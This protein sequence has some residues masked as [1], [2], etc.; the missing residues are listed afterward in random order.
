MKR[1][2]FLK[3]FIFFVLA[4]YL[5][6]L[7]LSIFGI[8]FPFY[9]LWFSYGLIF[10]ALTLFPRFI[11]FGINTNLWIGTVL[12]LSGSFGILRFH[13]NI[14]TLFSL[15]GYLFCFA[16]ASL[17]MFFFFRQIFHLKIFTFMLFFAIIIFVYEWGIIS[18]IAFVISLVSIF[19]FAL[20]FAVK[21]I[22]SNTRKV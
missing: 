20:F 4:T 18:L 5:T 16:S 19:A 1:L 21:A 8:I 6:L 13:L 17:I 15:A 3:L 10:I 7:M 9:K 11:S 14:S 12:L 22:I 2:N